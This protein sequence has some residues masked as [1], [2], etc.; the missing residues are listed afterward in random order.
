MSTNFIMDTIIQSYPGPAKRSNYRRHPV[1]FKRAVVEQSLTAG[2]SVSLVARK[3]DINANQ[4]FAWRKLYK[5]GLL[6][7][8]SNQDC[9]LLPVTLAELP[10]NSPPPI[11]SREITTGAAGVIHLALGKAQLPL[12]GLSMRRRWRSCLSTCCDDRL[13]CWYPDLA[14]RRRHRCVFHANWTPVPP[15]TGQASVPAGSAAAPHL[16][17]AS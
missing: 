8:E 10:A 15:Q 13:A 14:G 12:T 9:K 3:H 1:D 16:F 11:G 6:D 2:A 5:E 7:A 4:V 17:R